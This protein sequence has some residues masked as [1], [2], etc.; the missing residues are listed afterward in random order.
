MQTTELV[1]STDGAI[2][3]LAIFFVAVYLPTDFGDQ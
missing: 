1:L 2:Y 3:A